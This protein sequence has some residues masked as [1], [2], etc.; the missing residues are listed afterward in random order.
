MPGL[1]SPLNSIELDQLRRRFIAAYSNTFPN[2]DTSPAEAF[3]QLFDYSSTP[4]QLSTLTDHA[5][6]LSDLESQLSTPSSVSSPAHKSLLRIFS[7]EFDP[8]FQSPLSSLTVTPTT[9]CSSSPNPLLQIT[10]QLATSTAM[11]APTIPMPARG[12]ATAPQF[13]AEQPRELR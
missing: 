9:S 13:S 5:E 6:E 3:Q 7:V 10:T 2:D 4:D 11:S 1:P 8:F 12:H